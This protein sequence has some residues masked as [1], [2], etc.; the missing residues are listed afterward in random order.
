MNDIT[1]CLYRIKQ[2][3]KAV[4]G[5][6]ARE[7]I[8]EEIE[9]DFLDLLELIKLFLIS[10]RDSYYGYFLM[11]MQFRAN[12]YS[13][14]IAGIKLNE[15]PPVLEANPLLL[16]KFTLKEIIYVV[17]HEIDHVLL[18]HPAE[19]VKAN[20]TKDPDRFYQFNLAADASVNDRIDHEIVAEKHQF[21]SAPDGL[22]TSQV[23][24]KMFNLGRIR[25]MENYAYYFALIEN[26]KP[27]K[28]S[29]DQNGQQSMM[30]KQNQKDAGNKND[31]QNEGDQADKAQ[32][33][34]SKSEGSQDT[35]GQDVQTQDAG[36]QNSKSEGAGGQKDRKEAIDHGS[37]K[38]NDKPSDKKGH[39]AQD[40]DG[41]NEGDQ[42][43]KA[44]GSG[45]KSEGA[46]D[47]RGQ[48][49]ESQDSG[50]LNSKSEGT[51][52]QGTGS[53]SDKNGNQ[54]VTAANCGKIEDH[55]W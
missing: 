5:G 8:L 14:T 47:S 33:S 6:D 24:S 29:G 10:E 42:A 19:M 7:S 18:N 51:D 41:Q 25:P 16:C 27:G 22:I 53:S 9:S 12:F 4:E 26:K 17:C 23:I 46:Q 48:N 39:K 15:F 50:G 44:Q 1:A 54:V 31:G 43:D 37:G 28:K 11:N 38:G 13:N 34:G 55:N 35:R 21:M 32:G 52:G 45:T 49:A 40:S 3:I 2:N 36:E 20:P 30:S